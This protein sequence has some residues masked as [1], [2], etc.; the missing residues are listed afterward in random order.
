MAS[1]D[2]YNITDSL[3]TASLDV[4]VQRLEARGAHP[5]TQSL[6]A[7]YSRAICIDGMHCVLDL[8]AGTG[9]VA[10]AIARR[11]AFAGEV[12]GIDRAPH[13][14]RAAQELAYAEGLEGRVQFRVGD[15]SQLVLDDGG[16]DTVIAHTLLSHVS[17]QGKT[18][19]EA[20]RAL[21]VG[22]TLVI[23]DLDFASLTFGNADADLGKA[24]DLA[25][26]S[27]VAT[28]PRVMRDLPRL[29]KSVGLELRQFFHRNIA[30]AGRADYWLPA[31]ES[32]RKLLPRAGVMTEE[33]ANLFADDLI[34]DSERGVFFAAAN[35]YTYIARKP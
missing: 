18:L 14:V 29:L 15:S 30:E 22:G 34:R 7:E 4:I 9:V 25:L 20:T 2:L 31:I 28:N 11:P 23:C 19:L 1:A 33:A 8:G 32:F 24:N 12:T 27:A 26:V 3:D 16:F 10:R 17:D 21:N 5:I 13:L 6:I 35:Y